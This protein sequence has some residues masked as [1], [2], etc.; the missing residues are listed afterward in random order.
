M[1]IETDTEMAELTADSVRDA[2]LR[3]RLRFAEGIIE[4]YDAVGGDLEIRIGDVE[5]AVM[6]E[7]AAAAGTL[8]LT[9]DELVQERIDFVAVNPWRLDELVFDVMVQAHEILTAN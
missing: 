2:L 5:G 3:T 1:T 9:V 6:V 8:D 4:A 7:F